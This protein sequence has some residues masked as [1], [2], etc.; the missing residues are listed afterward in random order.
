MEAARWVTNQ[1]LLN[2]SDP[3]KIQRIPVPLPQDYWSIK[4]VRISDSLFED[5][6]DSGVLIESI[7][8]EHLNNDYAGH[9]VDPS[10]PYHI[11]RALVELVREIERVEP[12]LDQYHSRLKT[13]ESSIQYGI[14]TF[15]ESLARQR[16]SL[17]WKLIP[18]FKISAH[19]HLWLLWISKSLDQAV[20]FRNLLVEYDHYQDLGESAFGYLAFPALLNTAVS[21]TAVL[22]ELG[23]EYL[24]AFREADNQDSYNHTTCNSVLDDLSTTFP[25]FDNY[26]TD[27]IREEVVEARDTFSHYMINRRDSVSTSTLDDF[28][29]AIGQA[30]G[31]ITSLATDL[32]WRTVRE[33][34]QDSL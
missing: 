22:E 4:A 11:D 2:D 1:L 28:V 21:C 3:E 13:A 19:T 9:V 25:D 12:L 8:D 5:I 14:G 20:Q 30:F 17:S 6:Q 32:I 31:L 27:L 16:L 24:Q 23:V 7:L 34:E 33:Q 29:R 18:R 15:Y 10:E 26:E